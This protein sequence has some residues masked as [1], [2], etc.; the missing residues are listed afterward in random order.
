MTFS[1]DGF[2]DHL[3]GYRDGPLAGWLLGQDELSLPGLEQPIDL[4]VWLDIDAA[5][6]A[7]QIG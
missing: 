1:N 3:A 2:A 6:P 4:A 7:Q 5:L